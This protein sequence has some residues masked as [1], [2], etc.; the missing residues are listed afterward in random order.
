[1]TTDDDWLW[2]SQ[3]LISRTKA[4]AMSVVWRKVWRESVHNKVR[5]ALVVLSIAVGVFAPGLV[6]NLRHALQAWMLDDAVGN[7][8]LQT[9]LDFVY[10]R[11][12]AI[13]WLLIVIGLSALASLLPALRAA[14]WSV[15]EML[16]YE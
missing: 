16:A 7:L 8:L 15:R 14:Q 10:S 5:T 4:K 13:E 9:P 11:E 3:Y 2:T 6:F 1:M 12:G